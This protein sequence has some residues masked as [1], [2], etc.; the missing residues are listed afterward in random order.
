MQSIIRTFARDPVAYEIS[1]TEPDGTKE[2]DVYLTER[3]AQWWERLCMEDGC[4][5]VEMR[6]VY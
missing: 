3:M 2:V 6:P 5:D 4:R 1:Y